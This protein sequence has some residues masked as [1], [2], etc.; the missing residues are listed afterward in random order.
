[1][2]DRYTNSNND[3]PVL[4][5]M[6]NKR[7]PVPH[8]FFDLSRPIAFDA[9]MGAIIPFDLI[10]TLPD[11]DYEISYD[12][13]AITRNPLVRRLLNGVNIYVHTY[14]VDMKDLWEGFP[15]FL[16]RGR[17]GQLI[18]T[19]PMTSNRVPHTGDAYFYSR[20]CSP[21]CY[22]GVPNVYDASPN[23]TSDGILRY[24]PIAA[25]D[26]TSA[27][28]ARVTT[29]SALPLV[30]YQQICI[31]NYLPS[32]LLQDNQHF[33]PENEL[34]LRLSD[35]VSDSGKLVYA[36]SYDDSVATARAV[37]ANF[38]DVSLSR[39]DTPVFLDQLRVRQ[40][41][42]DAFSTG[43]PWP[44][45]LRGDIPSIS[46]AASSVTIPS[47]QVLFNG[48]D[49]RVVWASTNGEV[50]GGSSLLY[51]ADYNNVIVNGDSSKVLGVPL[52]GNLVNGS[53][54]LAQSTTPGG[55]DY[56]SK[57][58]KTSSA[59]T[60]SVNISTAVTQ[61]QLNAL[62]VLTLMRQRAALTDGSY[63]ELFKAQYNT[64]PDLHVGKPLYIGGLKQP[65]VF[66][67]VVQQ[68]ESS[69]G[70]ALGT[71][72]SRAVSAGN[73]YIGKYH[74]KDFGY[75]MSVLMVV[76][77][78]YYTQGLDKLWSRVN[79]DDFHMPL[80]DELSPLPILNKELYL[81]GN[82]AV[83][84]N[85]FAYQERDYEYKSRRGALRAGLAA[86]DSDLDLSAYA[87]R[88]RFSTTPKLSYGFTGM[89]P[90]NLDYSVFSNTL[91]TPFIFSIN[92]RVKAT[93]PLPYVTV[94]NDG[95]TRL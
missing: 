35:T 93:Q 30:M 74:S 51:E 12:I 11:S 73:G 54:K 79:H 40:F 83:D 50:R 29:F 65:I 31:H 72:G 26:M 43:L 89:F 42:G 8:S 90:S 61:S 52:A 57:Q 81:S 37:P 69:S 67:E 23:I 27:R 20:M 48:S 88:R 92:S 91:D 78:V 56:S 76:P 39:S 95:L 47:G 49:I 68:S 75:I 14:A 64:S 13:L 87:M 34:H 63:N 10:E 62:K 55:S 85:V 25:V 1:M 16:T 15:A 3:A 84:N 9:F 36:L 46:L 94:P 45:L 5:A 58:V 24:V 28:S 41:N 38:E 60:G 86:S 44:E 22:L 82:A 80:M 18:K 59:L 70:S 7:L 2:A 77:D 17:S 66:N 6:E 32:N 19:V 33:F 4:T 53:M 71:T 21:S